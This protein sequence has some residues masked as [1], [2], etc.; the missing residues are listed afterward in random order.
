M[1]VVMIIGLAGSCRRDELVHMLVEDVKDEGH[2]FRVKL[3]SCRR[4]FIILGKT[5]NNLD[6]VGIIR[7]YINLRPPHS[8]QNRQKRFFL[9]YRNGAVNT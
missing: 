9:A 6:L 5:E 3:P 4:E 1:K 8:E 7:K 2:F